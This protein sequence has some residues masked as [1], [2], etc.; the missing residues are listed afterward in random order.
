[1]NKKINVN[2]K[3]WTLIKNNESVTTAAN[4]IVLTGIQPLNRT[5]ILFLLIVNTFSLYLS[6]HY[7]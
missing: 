5:E 4:T 7:N 6:L 2:K 1:M 3:S